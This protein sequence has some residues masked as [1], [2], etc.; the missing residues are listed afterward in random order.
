[1]TLATS[2]AKNKSY[3]KTKC[4]KITMWQ[5]RLESSW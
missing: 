2:P 1:L 3:L 5:R 4:S